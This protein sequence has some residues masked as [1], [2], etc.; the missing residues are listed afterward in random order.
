MGERRLRRETVEGF[1]LFVS[2]EARAVGERRYLERRDF[3]TLAAMR[4]RKAFS[5]MNPAASA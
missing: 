3:L 1:P 5:R 4:M 2:G